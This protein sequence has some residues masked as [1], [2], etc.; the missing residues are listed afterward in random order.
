MKTPTNIQIIRDTGGYPEF[1]VIPFAEFQAL[2]LGKAKVATAIPS[3]VVNLAMDKNMS[4]TKAWREY[5][6]LTQS[7]LA[8]RIGISQSAYAQLEAKKNLRK[9]TREKI[10]LALGIESEQLDF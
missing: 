3:K 10:A 7:E 1:V 8:D 6:D 2:K 4:A 5:L 9:S